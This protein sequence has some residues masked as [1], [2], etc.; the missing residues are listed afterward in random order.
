MIL[1]PVITSYSIHYT[2]LYE[3]SAEQLDAIFSPENLKRPHYLARR[4]ARDNPDT[5]GSDT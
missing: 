3:L 4:Y 1:A 2:K 5:P